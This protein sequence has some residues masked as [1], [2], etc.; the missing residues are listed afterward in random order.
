MNNIENPKIIV[1]ENGREIEVDDTP[2]Y[3]KD[4]WLYVY[5]PTTYGYG[6]ERMAKVKEVRE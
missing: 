6:Y 5:M 4:G 2:Y 1:L 3:I